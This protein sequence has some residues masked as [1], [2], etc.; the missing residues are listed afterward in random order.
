LKGRHCVGALPS[1]S[2][3]IEFLPIATECALA[4]AAAHNAG[5]VHH[6]IK[7]ENI[8]LTTSGQVKVLDFGVAKNLPS[9]PEATLSAQTWTEFAGTLN[10]MAP[11]A[12]RE[13]ESD[14][15]ADI[16]SLGI[17]FLR[18]NCRE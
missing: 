10:Y 17:V 15:R 3:I 13:E 9:Q 6:D 16:F 14:S 11:E 12:V 1:R 2:Q 4:L 7:P 8:M 18:G 5:V